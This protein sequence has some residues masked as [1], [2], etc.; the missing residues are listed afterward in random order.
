VSHYDL[1]LELAEL[2]LAAVSEGRYDDLDEL[3]RVQAELAES[4]PG[5]PPAHARPALERAAELNERARA[6]AERDM[7][8]LRAE[9]GKLRQG[10]QAL[11]AYA[12]SAR[13]A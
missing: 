10:Q 13:A 4:L 9:M 5:T 1:I 11:A 12:A 7:Q 2:Q 3:Q 6:V 8:V